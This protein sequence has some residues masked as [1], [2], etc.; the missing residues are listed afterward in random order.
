MCPHSLILR[1]Q[2]QACKEL[3]DRLYRSK[4][5]QQC[6]KVLPGTPEFPYQ[7][8]NVKAAPVRPKA[9]KVNT[10]S[11][12]GAYNKTSQVRETTA[13]TATNGSGP[14]KS[15]QQTNYIQTSTNNYASN[16]NGYASN[17]NG[18]TDTSVQQ[19]AGH[20]TMTEQLAP[21]WVEYQ[22]PN[23]GRSYY[24]NTTTGATT[25]EK[26]VDQNA[27]VQQ[28]TTDSYT[29]NAS[30]QAVQQA[31]QPSRSNSPS[32]LASKYGDGFVTSASHPE[33]GAQYGNVG[34]S[35]PY[36]SSRPGIAV[37]GKKP[38]KAPVSGTFNL[39]KLSEVADSTEYKATVDD[40]LSIV[41]S[42]S[43]LGLQGSEKKLLSEVE[44][45]T[46]I[47]SKR[48]GKSDIDNDAAQKVGQI[49]EAVKNRDFSTANAIH[50]TMVNSIWKENKDWLKGIKYL[51]QLSAKRM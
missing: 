7:F 35:N 26:P 34:T 9:R 31:Q 20:T 33:L 6:V 39:K 16:A 32:K 12:R 51:I 27:A 17:S 38:E 1:S 29:N 42:L 49:V 37:V 48:L 14:M 30:T 2:K 41:T 36:S 13:H 11:Q 10:N 3:Q 45:G 47:F 23:S 5:S 18:Y 43:S 44:K 25:W 40:L 21:G 46:A 8:I 50:A 22:D 15:A 4:D 19:T 24:A 28:A